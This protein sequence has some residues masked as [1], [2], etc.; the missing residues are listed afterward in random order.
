MKMRIDGTGLPI[1]PGQATSMPVFISQ[2]GFSISL[3]SGTVAK[4]NG[5]ID[6]FTNIENVE[7]SHDNDI[8]IGDDDNNILN[9]IDGDDEIHGGKGNDIITIGIGTSNLFGEDGD[10]I[11]KIKSGKANIYGGEGKNVVDFIDYQLSSIVANLSQS[12]ISYGN[13]SGYKLENIQIIRGTNYS[14]IIYDTNDSNIIAGG[15]GDDRIYSIGGNDEINAG[16]GDDIVYLS[17]Q[18]NRKLWGEF[19]RDTYVI[20]PDFICIDKN[21][22]VITDFDSTSDRIDLSLL[23]H[24]NAINDLQIEDITEQRAEL[25]LVRIDQTKSLTLL[26]LNTGK[27]SEDNFIF[28]SGSKHMDS[29]EELSS[30]E[31]RSIIVGNAAHNEYLNTEWR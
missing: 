13:Y 6:K 10:D 23:S 22:T 17:G 14:D 8:I 16:E 28:Y 15:N 18:G 27:L 4:P 2:K 12:S 24:I 5:L 31:G 26:K 11:F 9:G 25:S 7:A 19:G 21:G 29:D 20:L 3:V 1:F 30:N